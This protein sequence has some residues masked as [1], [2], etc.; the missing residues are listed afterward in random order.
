MGSILRLGRFL[1]GGNR[2]PLQDSCLGN[3]MDREVWWATVRGITKS[4]TRPRNCV[5]T[6]HFPPPHTHVNKGASL[7]AVKM[8]AVVTSREN[9]P[10]LPLYVCFCTIFYCFPDGASG[11]ELPASA[12]DTRD[13]GSVP[14][15]GRPPGGGH[16]N[17]LWHS[18][19]EN[20][21]DRGPGG[22]QSMGSQRVGHSWS[23]LAHTQF[24]ISLPFPEQHLVLWCQ[25]SCLPISFPLKQLLSWS[26]QFCPYLYSPDVSDLKLGKINWVPLPVATTG[27]VRECMDYCMRECQISVE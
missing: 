18:C 1:G 11:K 16:S 2:D 19:L 22:L 27:K 14:G 21:M 5:G 15:S 8:R 17:P 26:W 10:A 12:G 7:W 20:P 4:Q 3:P 24:I 23:H 13:T 9:F 25:Q 6:P